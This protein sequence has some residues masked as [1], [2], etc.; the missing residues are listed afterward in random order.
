MVFHYIRAL[1]KLESL[2]IEFV[3]RSILTEMQ[4]VDSNNNAPFF[5]SLNIRLNVTSQTSCIKVC[6]FVAHVQT[7][8][9][10]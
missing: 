6:V 4:D 2:F 1:K 7:E 5:T 8:P 3:L 10:E 9:L